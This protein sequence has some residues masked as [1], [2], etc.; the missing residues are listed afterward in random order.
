MRLPLLAALL[1]FPALASGCSDDDDGRR[2]G[3]D[4]APPASDGAADQRPQDATPGDARDADAGAGTD[5]AADGSVQVDAGGDA[6]PLAQAASFTVEGRLTATVRPGVPAPVGGV[7]ERHDFTLRLLPGAPARLIVG[8]NGV[9]VAADLRALGPGQWETTAPLALPVNA[10]SACGAS[11]RYDRFAIAASADVLTGTAS[12]HLDVIQGDV[13]F[14]FDAT[15][16]MTGARDVVPPLLT[17]VAPDADPL[18]GFFLA[19]SEPLPATSQARLTAGGEIVPLVAITP[20]ADLVT[21]FDKPSRA[22]RYGTTYQLVVQPWQ[23]LA[24]N[25][26]GPL[27]GLRTRA[28]PPQIAEDGFEAAGT[29]PGGGRLVDAATLPPITGVRSLLVGALSGYGGGGAPGETRFT[30]RLAVSAGDRVVKLALRAASSLEGTLS[31]YGTTLRVA[32]PGGAVAGA[33][34]PTTEATTPQQVGANRVFLGALRTVELPIP[35]G[36]AGEVVFD[37]SVGDL[38]AGCGLA[39]PGAAYLVDDLRA[40]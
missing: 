26:G 8:R 25:A 6:S 34:F 11:A 17:A 37:L 40:E 35:A 29:S 28:A 33:T 13:V 18:A 12:G 21:G 36:A 30:A 1:T 23:D 2:T 31:S 4:A 19:A 20:V 3:A 38:G 14:G 16:A 10:A 5:L 39:P 22:L 32:V 9:A 15:L 7:P 24:G 27:P